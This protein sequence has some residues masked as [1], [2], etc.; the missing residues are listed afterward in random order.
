[1]AFLV[2]FAVKV[3]PRQKVLFPPGVQIFLFAMI[4][5]MNL[6]VMDGT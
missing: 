1:L 6:T 2:I 4:L 5:F 3:T